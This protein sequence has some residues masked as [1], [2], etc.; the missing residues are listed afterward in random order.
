MAREA[1][2]V[3]GP[4]SIM[5][6]YISNI[7][8]AI[9]ERGYLGPYP[10]HPHAPGITS[11]IIIHYLRQALRFQ[12]QNWAL[13]GLLRL[14]RQYKATDPRDK[15][16][17]VMGV[18][19]NADSIPVDLKPDYGLST[20]EVFLSVAIHNLEKL[21]N[22]ELLAQA[23][24]SS[25]GQ[26]P[27]LP[28][29]V[30]DWI[31]S[32]ECRA[33]I[34]ATVVKTKFC[35]AGD[36]QPTLSI[37]AD[38]KI[39]TIRGAVIDTISQLDHSVHY[40]EEDLKL[41]HCTEAGQARMDL[42]SKANAE[43]F[44][45]LAEA[46]YEFPGG[47]TREESLWRTLCC[48][49][50]TEIP[51]QRAPVEYAIAYKVCRKQHEATNAEG[52]IDLDAFSR[53]IVR[54]DLLHYTAFHNTVLRHCTGRNLCV[55][56]GGY[57]GNVPDGSLNG[58]KI[59]ILFGSAVPLVLRECEGGFFKLVGECYIHGIMDGEAMRN[60]DIETLSRDFEII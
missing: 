38:K 22:L 60:R 16:F 52:H 48:D 39:L 45:A 17:A 56:T 20:E 57:L 30:P 43:N 27:K 7:A 54:E 3:C 58:D 1:T 25:A 40:G 21:K 47:H 15:V 37:S 49:Q 14:T 13:L 8:I 26:N 34:A 24:A 4:Y 29:W 53:S 10:V 44:E 2:V 18:V 46:A 36:S 41:D 35:S 19:T 6:E 33:V 50:T 51:V 31:Y 5:W 9:R 12:N 11:A 59:C 23:G 42:R 28:S 55:T 32:N